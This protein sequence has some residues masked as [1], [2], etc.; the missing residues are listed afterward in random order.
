[1]VYFL[2]STFLCVLHLCC[3]LVPPAVEGGGETSYF[4]V[5]VNSL[6]ELECQVTGSPPPTIM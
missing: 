4:I 5:M 2:L 1:M 3:F 6:L